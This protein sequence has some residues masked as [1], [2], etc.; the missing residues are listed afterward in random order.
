MHFPVKVY[1]GGSRG[2]QEAG[3]FKTVSFQHPAFLP[4]PVL[5][6]WIEELIVSL[7]VP[8]PGSPLAVPFLGTLLLSF[9][10]SY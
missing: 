9:L 3:S 7:A 8:F 4:H 2:P 10:P 6:L 5:G 1:C